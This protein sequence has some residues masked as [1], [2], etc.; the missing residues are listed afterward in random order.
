M[1]AMKRDNLHIIAPG[2]YFNEHTSFQ[3]THHIRQPWLQKQFYHPYP[4]QE[5][6][7]SF[8]K[9]I[10]PEELLAGLRRRF[11]SE[12]VLYNM[13][14]QDVFPEVS[15]WLAEQLEIAKKN[16]P[17]EGILAWRDCASLNE[18]ARLKGMRVIYNELGP[19]RNPTHHETFFWDN[20]G[21]KNSS[22]LAR[23]FERVRSNAGLRKQ[24]E[25]WSGTFLPEL[26]CIPQGDNCAVLMACEEDFVF[27]RGLS[28]YR[29]LLYAKERFPGKRL[30]ARPHP[31]GKNVRYLDADG[32]DDSVDLTRIARDCG[33]AVTAYSNA[34][35]ELLAKGLRVHFLGDTPLR[36]LSA[37]NLSDDERAWKVGFFCLNYLVPGEFMFNPEYYRW[38][39]TGPE[40]PEILERH[41]KIWT[42]KSACGERSLF[43]QD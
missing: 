41:A 30:M 14:Q 43:K 33:H 36:F 18:A 34:G 20:E 2:Y 23:R 15:Q 5:T 38:R 4:T 19:F 39:L 13:L 10:F 11:P 32:Y 31:L 16:A 26:C 9:S 12:L 29:L 3:E 37:E 25:E 8:P 24:Y 21:V 17:I 1:G 40:E 35:V 42:E 6:I 22:E 27:M 7:D 28:N